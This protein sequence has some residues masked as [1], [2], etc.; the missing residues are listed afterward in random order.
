MKENI[1]PETLPE[2]LKNF[3]LTGESAPFR[4]DI[5]ISPAGVKVPLIE[6]E[7]WTAA[8]RE[9]HS[10]H[11]VPYR[12]CFKS[13]LP[14]FFIDLFTRKGDRVYD[15]FMGRGTTLLESALTS[16]IPCGCDANPLSRMLITPRLSPPTLEEVKTRLT[17][18]M[19]K[20]HSLPERKFTGKEKKLLVFYHPE[21][22]RTLLA[23]RDLW[24]EAPEEKVNSWIRMTTLTRLTGHSSGFFSVYTLPPNQAVTIESQKKINEKRNQTPPL[25]NT[26]K[27]LL[28]KSRLL[29]K[30]TSLLLPDAQ[31]VKEAMILTGSSDHTPE[32]PSESIS[33]IV[34][35]PPFLD[36]VNYA[37]DNCIRNF[38]ASI[39]PT[40]IRLTQARTLPQWQDAMEKTFRELAR[41]LKKGGWIAFETGEVKHGKVKLEGV[42]LDCGIKAGLTPCCVAVNTQE[43]S[44]TSHCWGIDN[45]A[46]GTNSN[47]IAVFCKK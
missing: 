5:C 41:V 33:L 4:E 19:K 24:E 47:R 18:F 8:K 28:K 36:V 14:R 31:L 30:D 42:V 45:N 44:K 2:Y 11:E 38:F 6:N 21:T 25:R 43:F 17:L 10:L 32:I 26:E 34:T 9:C 16:R 7:F 35:S 13:N 46:K 27:I 37:R 29:L 40:K 39:D 23:L 12:A 3:H 1:T 15:P 20:I 22:L